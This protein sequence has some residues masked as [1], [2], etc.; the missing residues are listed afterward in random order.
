L[1]IYELKSNINSILK[2]KSSYK[3]ENE[4]LLFEINEMINSEGSIFQNASSLLENDGQIS[5]EIFI[6]FK[7]ID[8]NFKRNQ[9]LFEFIRLFL[10]K[11]S[12]SVKK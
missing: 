9:F 4:R 3:E 8:V 10:K 6:A 11:I 2:Q 12:R 7:E 1:E 5:E